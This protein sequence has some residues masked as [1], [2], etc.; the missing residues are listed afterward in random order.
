MLVDV[1]LLLRYAPLS[2]R[3]P[4]QEA[5]SVCGRVGPCAAG[6]AEEL[7]AGCPPPEASDPNGQT[8][9]RAMRQ[10]PPTPEDLL[11][12]TRQA[13]GR[14][15]DV[16]PCIASALSVWESHEQCAAVLRFPT[17]KSHLVAR[18][19]LGAGSGCVLRTGRNQGHNSWWNCGGFD[20]AQHVSRSTPG[21]TVS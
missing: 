3:A 20:A 10:V 12:V 7:P 21:G 16:T 13:P 1:T 19:H 8:F 6:W 15:L 5:T 2:N 17:L 9:F 4:R 14:R 11:P 18:V